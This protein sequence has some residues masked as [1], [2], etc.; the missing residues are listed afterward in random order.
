MLLSCVLLMVTSLRSRGSQPTA[1]RGSRCV[2]PGLSLV[3]DPG[4]RRRP[5]G[6]AVDAAFSDRRRDA[7]PLHRLAVL[8]VPHYRVALEEGVH[9]T[10]IT[11]RRSLHDALPDSDSEVTAA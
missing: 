8:A 10:R 11:S 9:Q 6:H 5:P 1:S 4:R 2:A 3:A 7:Y